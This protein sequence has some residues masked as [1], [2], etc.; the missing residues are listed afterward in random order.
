MIKE[1]TCILCPMGCRLTV[2][3]PAEDPESWKVS[4]NGCP[5]GVGHALREMTHPMRTL[6]T[7]LRVRGG[8]KQMVSVKTSVPIP[9]ERLLDVMALLKG[10]IVPAP[11]SL[12]Q[13][14]VPHVGG[15]E[16]DLIATAPVLGKKEG[17]SSP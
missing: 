7:C 5:R 16:A 8:E 12:G 11:I 13:V 14:L 10:T 4:G 1:M 2:S 9:K 15:L 3:G 17:P 6:T